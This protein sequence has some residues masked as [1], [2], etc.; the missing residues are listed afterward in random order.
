MFAFTFGLKNT[1]GLAN[2][3]NRG[4]VLRRLS[5]LKTNT[6][7]NI[8]DGNTEIINQTDSGAMIIQFLRQTARCIL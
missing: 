3:R 2:F 5:F 4:I 7:R 8:V 1:R 6:I